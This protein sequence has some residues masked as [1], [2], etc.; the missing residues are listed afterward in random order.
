MVAYLAITAQY[1]SARQGKKD[2]TEAN[3][4]APEEW[5]VV[6]AATVGLALGPG[7][8][9]VFGAGVF[10]HPLE[11]EFGWTRSQV[12][13]GV[14][15][16]HFA[17]L[18]ISVLQ[19]FL[20]DRF[21]TRRL[22]LPSIPLFAAGLAA[23]FFLPASLATY[24]ALMALV[25]LLAL[26]LWP[27]A[28]LRA[29]SGWF[30]RRLGLAVGI[31]NAGVG[32]GGAIIPIACGFL[33]ATVGWR[34]TYLVLAAAVLVITLPMA[35]LFLRDAPSE[36]PGRLREASD[37]AVGIG[38]LLKSRTFWLLAAAFL[39]FGAVSGAIIAHQVPLLID[40]GWTPRKAALAQG[41]FGAAHIVGRL[42]AGWLLD[43]LFAPR[44]MI[45]FLALAIGGCAID[46]VGAPGD[47]AFVAAIGFGL[48]VGAEIDVLAYLT[49]RYF[50]MA[51]FGRIF[52]SV[53]AIFQIGAI[54]GVNLLSAIHENFGAY[55]SGMWILAA[56]C[57]VLIAI[58][59]RF[60]RYSV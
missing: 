57:A 20:L 10:I 59:T 44:I 42:A 9:L 15:I 38:A 14:S 58:F 49:R 17:I 54:L 29:V 55:S 2:R 48:L 13:F 36:A 32:V 30:D 7:A 31:A 56:I 33:I 22:A 51:A 4:R 11:L 41:L 46:A 26:G 27:T 8:I 1:P 37:A 50:G 60:R 16:V 6:A 43:L 23:F 35:W 19:G 28:Y 53:F 25:P 5:K 47:A 52:G 12:A 39:L 21:G 24:Y 40:A 34:S 3:M 18:F 45:G